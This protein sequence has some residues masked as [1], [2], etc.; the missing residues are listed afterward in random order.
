MPRPSKRA[1]LETGLKLDLNRLARGGYI[2]PGALTAPAI[3]RWRD[4]YTRNQ[5][6]SG[7]ITADMRGETEGWFRI[8]L[9]NLDQFVSLVA[10]SRRLAGRKWFFVCPYTGRH[11]S[12]LWMPPG[13]QSFACRQ[14]WGDQVAYTS[15][16]LD[17]ASRAHYGQA[18]I[19]RRLCSMGGFDPDEWDFP[20]KPKG[21]EWSTYNRAEEAFNR[22]EAIQ[23]EVF[24]ASVQ[25]LQTKI[26]RRSSA[27]APRARRAT[28]RSLPAADRRPSYSLKK[29]RG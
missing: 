25:R 21:M 11:A 28:S 22:Y 26:N 12:V 17:R 24:V 20:P 3:I 27:T 19:K 5:V 23:N 6:A 2:Q 10:V 13:A 29:K 1:P 18:R 8:Q 9:S 14:K 16:F 4:A 15:Q 7:L